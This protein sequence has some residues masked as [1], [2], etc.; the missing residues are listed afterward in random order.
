ME[1]AV[2]GL[3]IGEEFDQFLVRRERAVLDRLVDAGEFLV[4][5]P[6]RAEVQVPDFAVAHLSGGQADILARRTEPALGISLVE[7][8][9]EREIRQQRSIAFLPGGGRAFGADS[10]AIPDNKCDRFHR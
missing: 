5:D 10:P 8:L 6:A 9:V 3:E 1:R 7:V 2:L 4:N